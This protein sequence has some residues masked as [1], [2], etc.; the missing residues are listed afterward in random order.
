MWREDEGRG[1]ESS[2]EMDQLYPARM[3]VEVE[4]WEF[5]SLEVEYR[6]GR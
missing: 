3:F 1:L 5:G 6:A 2:K 4:V